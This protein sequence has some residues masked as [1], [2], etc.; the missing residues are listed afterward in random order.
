MYMYVNMYYMFRN[1]KS[2]KD[3]VK[4]KRIEAVIFLLYFGGFLCKFHNIQSCASV[5]AKQDLSRE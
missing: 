5:V 1:S 3:N 2:A 4:Q